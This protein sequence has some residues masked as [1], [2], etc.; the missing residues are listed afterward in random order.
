[1]N[2][3]DNGDGPEMR[4]VAYNKDFKLSA[5]YQ[6]LN[7]MPVK[8]HPVLGKNNVYYFENLLHQEYRWITFQAITA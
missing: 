6:K 1:M 7:A 3:Y 5:A 8:L 4:Y 2:V